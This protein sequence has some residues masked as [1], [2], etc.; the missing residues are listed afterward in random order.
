MK[1]KKRGSL[2]AVYDSSHLTTAARI[3]PRSAADM[4]R[5]IP[6]GILPW[7]SSMETALCVRIFLEC[8]SL[9]VVEE[10]ELESHS[11]R[12]ASVFYAPIPHCRLPSGAY[13]LFCMPI[14]HLS[15]PFPFGFIFTMILRQGR[16]CG[17]CPPANSIRQA[18]HS[19]IQGCGYT[20]PGGFIPSSTASICSGRF[21]L[22]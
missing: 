7:G 18:L 5:W 17:Y 21:F 20:I 10:L 14:L 1:F 15:P 19:G 9:F 22:H 13:S 12:L 8:H 4:L 6:R 11:R 2:Y 16:L 3:S